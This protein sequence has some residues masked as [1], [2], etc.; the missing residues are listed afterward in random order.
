MP[1]EYYTLKRVVI[2]DPK[3]GEFRLQSAAL[4]CCQLCNST[5]SGMGGPA[6]PDICVQCGDH[7]ER[8]QLRGAVIY[9]QVPDKAATKP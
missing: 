2:P 7:L 9:D 1:V 3:P 4:F 6:G 8:G 5:I